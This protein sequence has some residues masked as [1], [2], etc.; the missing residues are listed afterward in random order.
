[1]DERCTLLDLDGLELLW[2]GA[3]RPNLPKE[4]VLKRYTRGVK[5]LRYIMAEISR[6]TRVDIP[7]D[8][9]TYLLD[10]VVITHTANN[11]RVWAADEDLTKRDMKDENAR[12]LENLKKIAPVKRPAFINLAGYC[13]GYKSTWFVD[14]MKS[15][16]PDYVVV[17]PDDLVR[18]Y[19]EY[20]ADQKA[21]SK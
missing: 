13:W 15:L 16:P 18:L 19:R 3:G 8:E 10:D 2:S 11:F 12:M 4:G 7:T 20:Q 1:M 14:L 6:D 17:R 21:P 5:N 9:C